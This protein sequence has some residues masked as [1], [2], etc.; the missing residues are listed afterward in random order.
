[1]ALRA[2]FIFPVLPPQRHV[3]RNKPSLHHLWKNQGLNHR[4]T[5]SNQIINVCIIHKRP[6][7]NGPVVQQLGELEELEEN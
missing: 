6:T 3:Q 5:F 2:I 4:V 1:M 7:E